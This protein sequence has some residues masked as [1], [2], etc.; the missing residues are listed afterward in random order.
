MQSVA[1]QNKGLSVKF[2]PFT[3]SYDAFFPTSLGRLNSLSTAAHFAHIG[4]DGIMAGV[5][6]CISASTQ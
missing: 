2:I 4:I 5:E 3:E 6:C 1:Q